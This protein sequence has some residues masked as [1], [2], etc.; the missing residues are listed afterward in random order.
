MFLKSLFLTVGIFTFSSTVCLARGQPLKA[1]QA[2]EQAGAIWDHESDFHI[3]IELPGYG[4]ITAHLKQASDQKYTGLVIQHELGHNEKRFPAEAIKIYEA[5]K[6]KLFLLKITGSA[7]E[8]ILQK[9]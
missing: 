9:Y 2:T 8:F 6:K 7:S 4:P 1:Y 3:R 5:G